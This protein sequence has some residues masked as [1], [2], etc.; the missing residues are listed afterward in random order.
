MVS[1][2]E[3]Y[4]QLI[5]SSEMINLWMF[6]TNMRHSRFIYPGHYPYADI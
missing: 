1:L 4:R 6:L 5:Q 2:E 3:H